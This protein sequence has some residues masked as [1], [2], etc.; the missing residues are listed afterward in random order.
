M[1]ILIKKVFSLLRIEV[2]I[3]IIRDIFEIETFWDAQNMV[4]N[5]V[6]NYM[7][8]DTINAGGARLCLKY[9]LF[10]I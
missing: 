6:T 3:Y 5:Q 9:Y 4:S 1:D 2:D 10:Q 8:N 7:Y